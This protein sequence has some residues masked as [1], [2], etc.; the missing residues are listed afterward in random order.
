MRVAVEGS[1]LKSVD[2]QHLLDIL[3]DS[4]SVNYTHYSFMKSYHVNFFL[5]KFGGGG[6]SQGDI[7]P[8]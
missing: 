5:K 8:V 2:F 3:K 4:K 1:E 6:E 7:T